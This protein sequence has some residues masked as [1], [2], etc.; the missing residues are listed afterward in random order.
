MSERLCVVVAADVSAGYTC[1]FGISGLGTGGVYRDCREVVSGKFRLFVMRYRT[2]YAAD[3]DDIAFFGTSRGRDCFGIFVFRGSLFGMVAPFAQTF[4]VATREVAFVEVSE[5]GRR[6]GLDCIAAYGAD[7]FGIRAFRAGG[8]EF[9]R[10]ERMF[11]RR[12]V[13][14]VFYGAAG[15]FEHGISFFRARRS[16]D[17][18]NRMI[19][20][21]IRGFVISTPFANAMPFATTEV[22]VQNVP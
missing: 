11:R 4:P 22:G 3:R 19:V 21:L 16:D 20:F 18:R 17:R 8:F 7:A 9:L 15:A 10:N 12:H 5:S 2:A 13:I 1:I 14:S 6:D